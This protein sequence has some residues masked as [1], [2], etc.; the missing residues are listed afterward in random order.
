[1]RKGKLIEPKLRELFG[2]S[3]QAFARAKSTEVSTRNPRYGPR[4][5]SR[6]PNILLLL[7]CYFRK[8]LSSIGSTNRAKEK[9]RLGISDCEMRGF[10]CQ[11]SVEAH[12]VRSKA[13]SAKRIAVLHLRFYALR[14]ALCA[15]P[16]H[17]SYP[18]SSLFPMP[19]PFR[20]ALCALPQSIHNPQSKISIRHV[21]CY[22]LN[23]SSIDFNHG[24]CRLLVVVGHR[25]GNVPPRVSARM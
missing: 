18:T 25:G 11:M 17:I 23:T 21:L 15:M 16:S 24:C 2:F 14:Y 20:S 4:I 3:S 10:R 22:Y 13:Q 8:R 19:M 9:G 6:K 1:M 12:F 7:P 5:T